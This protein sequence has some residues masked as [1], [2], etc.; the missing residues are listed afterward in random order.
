MADPT[1][2]GL[3]SPDPAPRS[4]AR[5]QLTA[6]LALIAVGSGGIVF[7]SAR[8]WV[9]ARILRQPP[10]GPLNLTATGRHLYPALNGLALVALVVGV[11]VLVTGGWARRVLG[12]LLLVIGGWTG[13]YAVRGIRAGHRTHLPVQDTL[14][15]LGGRTTA[16]DGLAE[17]RYHPVW[18]YLSLLGSVL[19]LAA[20]LILLARAGR[21]H[22]GFSARYAAPAE[23][24]AG[25]DP[26]RQLDRGEDPTIRDG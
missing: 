13:W 21:W 14:R 4:A 2:D 3:G 6:A 1:A 23:A 18:A 12:A 16:A 7:V 9:S 11:L 22:S 15:L 8:P 17:L 10:F 24:G 19:L 25:G 20:G 26:W 5:R